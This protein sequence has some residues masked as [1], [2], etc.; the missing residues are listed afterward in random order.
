MAAAAR[1]VEYFFY[2]TRLLD[3][4]HDFPLTRDPPVEAPWLAPSSPLK[5]WIERGASST[6]LFRSGYSDNQGMV[7]PIPGGSKKQ[8]GVLSKKKNLRETEG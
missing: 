6:S 2:W 1:M 4:P 5:A 8:R 7:I 3:K